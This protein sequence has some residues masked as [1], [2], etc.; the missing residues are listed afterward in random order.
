MRSIYEQT[1]IPPYLDAQAST[2]LAQG[3][4]KFHGLGLDERKIVSHD[5]SSFLFLW[6]GDRVTNTIAVVLQ[7][8]G[9]TIQN[10]GVALRVS[11]ISPADLTGYLKRLVEDG[12]AA[13]PMALARAVP[14]NETEKFHYLLTEELLS[15]G[16][17]NS[18]LDTVG[19]WQTLAKVISP[20]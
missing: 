5:D 15:A 7:A 2:L 20:H 10:Q 6:R 8:A 14:N 3:R 9:L 16:Y 19:A 12:P 1:N 13:D 17:A 18:R 4:Q 11:G